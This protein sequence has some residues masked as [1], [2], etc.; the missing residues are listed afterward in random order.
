[1]RSGAPAPARALAWHPHRG[2]G[3]RSGE[4]PA[5]SPRNL[6]LSRVPA[7]SASPGQRTFVLALSFTEIALPARLPHFRPPS[8]TIS[9]RVCEHTHTDTQTHRHTD[10]QTQTHT[11]RIDEGNQTMLKYPQLEWNYTIGSGRKKISSSRLKVND[12]GFR[13][14][15]QNST[16]T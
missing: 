11:H 7:V 13:R 8:D 10:T 6:S 2:S 5:P 9:G 12:H 1:M 4:H 16:L 3:G 15:E 14:R